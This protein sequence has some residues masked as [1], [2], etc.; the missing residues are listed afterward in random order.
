[1]SSA[2]LVL[3][4]DVE[5][6]SRLWVPESPVAARS[7]PVGV[8][9]P[10]HFVAPLWHSSAADDAIDLA[11]VAGLELLPWQQ[12]VLRNA[13]GEKHDRWAAFEVGLVVPRQNGKGPSPR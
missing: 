1:M 4:G 8:Q 3:P 10:T 9:T 6:D 11:A 7:E 2:S 13:L 12:L 5:S